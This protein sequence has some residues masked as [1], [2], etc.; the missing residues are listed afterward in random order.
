ML[1]DKLRAATAVSGGAIQY[2]GGHTQAFAGTTSN[3]EINFS[4]DLTG[5]IDTSASDGDFVVV[6]YGTGSTADRDLVISGKSADFTVDYV[7]VADIVSTDTEVTNLAVAYGFAG[8]EWLNRFILTGGTGSIDDAGVVAIQVWRGVDLV[9]PLDVTTTTATGTN[10]VLCNPPAITPTSDGAVIVAGGAGAHTA[11]SIAVYSSSDLTDFDSLGSNDTN[12]VTIGLGYKEWISGAFDPA[13][14]TFSQSNSAAYSWAGVTMALRPERDLPRPEFIASSSVT[15]T[16]SSLS[17]PVPTGTAEGDLMIAVVG[18]NNL[19]SINTPTGWT[20]Q[21]DFGRDNPEMVVFSR[22]AGASEPADYAFTSSFGTISG[23]IL[24]YRG[25]SY[26]DSADVD[27][28]DSS[29]PAVAESVL[30]VPD[31]YSVWI[32]AAVSDG[33]NDFAAPAGF[34]VRSENLTSPSLIVCDKYITSGSTGTQSITFS[35]TS[36]SAVI[37]VVISPA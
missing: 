16:T 7:E 32:I 18:T 17:I 34:T 2:V 24:T 3:V 4:G 29:S 28:L 23:T 11:G 15:P 27:D 12:D 8:G 14:F 9:R 35:G 6:Y 25:A 22:V 33:T 26:F 5:G 36:A 13:A 37:S 30:S 31:D 1:A 20:R 19:S 10:S 21:R